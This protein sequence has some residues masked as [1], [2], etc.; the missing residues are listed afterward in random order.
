[1]AWLGRLALVGVGVG[2]LSFLVRPVFL[3][4]LDDGLGVSAGVGGVV[5]RLAVVL[6]GL[7]GID[8]YEGII[9]GK[10]RE[11]LGLLPVDPAQAVRASLLGLM[12]RR[13]WV[14]PGVAA[15]LLPIGLEA[16]WAAWAA[17]VLALAGVQLFAWPASAV[18]HLLAVE[19]ARSQAFGPLLDLVRGANPRAQAAF[20]YAPGVVLLLAAVI[21]YSASAGAAWVAEGVVTGWVWIGVGPALAVGMS[22]AV[23]SLARRSWFRGSAVLAEI[24]SAYAALGTSEVDR[25]HVY[26]DWGLRFL[27]AAWRR[28]ALHDLRHGWRGRRLWLSG[29][30]VLGIGAALAGWTEAAAGPGRALA[31]AALAA[32][33]VSSVILALEDD[34]PEFL[35]WWLPRTQPRATLARGVVVWAWSQPS[36]WPAVGITA[37]MQGWAPAAVV[38]GLSQLALLGVIGL[39]LSCARLGRVGPWVYGPAATAVVA[40]VVLPVGLG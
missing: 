36:V 26:L 39:G 30:W 13:W 25:L 28:D 32:A 11:V 27:P 5:L 20:V 33:A 14:I 17:A 29:A 1:M 22:L 23:P 24:D 2:A 10:D 37:F 18:V 38:L 19:V 6:V 15:L 40:A 8:V 3:G 7:A 12:G 16:S 35:R 31:V 34:E 9:R 4:F 21:A